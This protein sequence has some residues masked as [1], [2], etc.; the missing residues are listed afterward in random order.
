MRAI[1]LQKEKS[2]QTDG[3]VAALKEMFES[4]MWEMARIVI[5]LRSTSDLAEIYHTCPQLATSCQTIYVHPWPLD[6]VQ[7]V[8]LR[9]F[10]D[11][12]LEEEQKLDLVALVDSIQ[13]TTRS[14]NE[15]VYEYGL[16]FEFLNVAAT[17]TQKYKEQLKFRQEICVKAVEKLD[18]GAQRVTAMEED[19]NKW[20]QDL[21]A[22]K[23]LS[24]TAET[25][26]KM[27]R[28]EQDVEILSCSVDRAK[29]L[30]TNL[31]N[32]HGEWRTA[33]AVL[34]MR[35]A[36]C[37]LDS[38]LAAAVMTCCARLH[39]HQRAAHFQRWRRHALDTLDQ[40]LSD[41]PHYLSL[42]HLEHRETKAHWTMANLPND[43][44]CVASGV[45]LRYVQRV[46]LLIDPHDLAIKWVTAVAQAKEIKP[47]SLNM[48]APD[49]LEQL[50][51]CLQLGTLVIIDITEI[52]FD[53][54]IEPLLLRQTFNQGTTNYV[55]LGPNL[56]EYAAD[57]QLYLRSQTPVSDERV[58]LCTT[59]VDF[60]L[61]DQGILETLISALVNNE[62]PDHEE[63]IQLAQQM[64]ELAN[65]LDETELNLLRILSQ[66]D[67][68]W[69]EN[70]Q[71]ITTLLPSVTQS[72]LLKD[73]R[74]TLEQTKNR[75]DIQRQTFAP[76]AI[77]AANILSALAPMVACY[78]Q[79]HFP[80][81]RFANTIVACLEDSDD[82]DEDFDSNFSSIRKLT[83]RIFR[84][85][86]LGL[87]R[88]HRIIAAILMAVCVAQ[89]EGLC[90]ASFHQQ[91]LAGQVALPQNKVDDNWTQWVTEIS[92]QRSTVSVASDHFTRK[93]LRISQRIEFSECAL[94]VLDFA[95][96][97]PILM[98]IERG[99]N[100][101][102]IISRMAKELDFP[103][104][105]IRFNAVSGLNTL[106]WSE[107]EDCVRRGNWCVLQGFAHLNNVVRNVH[108][109]YEHLNVD[110][111]SPEFRLWIMWGY[112]DVTPPPSVL[113]EH[114]RSLYFE[115]VHT[116]EDCF[117]DVTTSSEFDMFLT[118]EHEGIDRQMKFK[119]AGLI[120][121]LRV[122]LWD[123][124][125]VVVSVYELLAAL[126]N[127]V[128]YIQKGLDWRETFQKVVT[129][130]VRERIPDQ[131]HSTFHSRLL[132]D[133]LN[134]SN[135]SWVAAVQLLENK[136]SNPTET[137]CEMST[138][139]A[140]MTLPEN[141][142]RRK[143]LVSE[144]IWEFL[145]K[146]FG[147]L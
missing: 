143:S 126:K 9:I 11:I 84:K 90:D 63:R 44:H 20:R 82:G 50:A 57:F 111:M 39:E 128:A 46:P 85:L 88:H 26:E 23:A 21:E 47:T 29:D 107:I 80:L 8:V 60:T 140:L 6:T 38:V 92:Q 2:L 98:L 144:Q 67:S 76:T 97:T 58:L 61:D 70:D 72:K 137:S 55:K 71:V 22:L 34:Q 49:Y 125:H 1:D 59:V 118:V 87:N 103:D 56:V 32:Y 136:W 66:S 24:E 93:F 114:A 45:M 10:A 106:N 33:A 142:A 40:Q 124:L 17:L 28:I 135:E 89:N 138:V 122:S 129:N 52:E 37:P 54:A 79:L 18:E 43:D 91:L 53:T 15:T 117:L 41:L 96:A 12:D 64:L 31:S 74:E 75:M 102:T 35:I 51:S 68:Y 146:S 16:F 73:K 121:V 119:L 99:L 130:M 101:L 78:G 48:S 25:A 139:F 113:L 94:A 116:A 133:L 100:M 81:E 7:D 105:R 108:T 13:Q 95:N 127:I 30:L 83:G 69:I 42:V 36:C 4:R 115:G 14:S 77:F 27:K 62:R 112:D 65:E 110:Y 147:Q 145:E 3:S 131:H 109:L 19:L 86:K 5:I 123:Q 104:D 141:E 134:D 132:P 120:I